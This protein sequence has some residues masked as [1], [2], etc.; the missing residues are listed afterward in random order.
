MEGI[1]VKFKKNK[2]YGDVAFSPTEL[3]MMLSQQHV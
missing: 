3:L 1:I 2:L